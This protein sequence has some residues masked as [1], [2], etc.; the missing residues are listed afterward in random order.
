ME[1]SVLHQLNIGGAGGA[2][3]IFLSYVIIGAEKRRS[4]PT[5]EN[6]HSPSVQCWPLAERID[7]TRIFWLK[8]YR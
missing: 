7:W 8:K 5:S 6:P 1:I 3:P 4:G 2:S